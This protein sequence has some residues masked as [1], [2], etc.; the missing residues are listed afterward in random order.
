VAA[1]AAPSQRSH[2][3]LLAYQGLGLEHPSKAGG[4]FIQ[5]LPAQLNNWIRR[6]NQQGVDGLIEGERPGRP[7]KITPEQSAHYRQLIEQPKLAD[8]LHWTAVKFHGYLRQELQHE[9]G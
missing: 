4:R 2:N 9:I 7:A 8:Q 5:H 1:K 6:F 3:R